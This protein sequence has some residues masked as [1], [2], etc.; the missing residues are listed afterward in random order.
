M[1]RRVARYGQQTLNNVRG[2]GKSTGDAAVGGR[3]VTRHIHRDGCSVDSQKETSALIQT[4]GSGTR[5]GF[6]RRD[7]KTSATEEYNAPLI[8]TLLGGEAADE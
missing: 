1:I 7:N 2:G 4:D 8:E 6:R 5:H 3:I